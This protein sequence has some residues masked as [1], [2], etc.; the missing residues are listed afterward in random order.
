MPM[1]TSVSGPECVVAE[2]NIVSNVSNPSPEESSRM[3]A[4]RDRQREPTVK[5]I[6]AA[7][8]SQPAPARGAWL[9]VTIS[10]V[11]LWASFTPLD[12]SPLA[13]I[14]LAPLSLLV[15]LERAPR[16][17]WLVTYVGGLLFWLP[18]LQWMRLG[19]A[20]MYAA[21]FALVVYQAAYWPAFVGLSRVAVHRFNLPLTF[22][23][24]LV[25]TGLEFVRAHLMTG[26]AW[27]FLGHSQYRWTELIQLS[28]VFGAYG[29]SFVV[30]LSSAMLAGLMPQSWL[31]GLR[32]LAPVQLPEELRH[33]PPPDE[34]S[35]TTA[36]TTWRRQ[37][38]S[39]A[40]CL[41]V[42]ATALGYGFVRRG[43]AEFQPG[44]RVALIQGNFLSSMKHD[45]S[46]FRK[47]IETHDVLTGYSVP[48]KPDIIIWPETMFRWPLSDFD[49]NLSESDLRRLVPGVPVAHWSD[50]T[51]RKR[52]HEMSQMSGANMLI[53]LD[54]LQ[55]ET[56]GLKHFNSV[57]FVTPDRGVSGTYD[58]LH[59][60]IFGE[61]IPLKDTFPWLK[62]FSP[63]SD[64]FG[65]TAGAGPVA[66]DCGRWRV[67]PI[68]CFEDTVPHLV[69]DIVRSAH[70][71][72]ASASAE[73][74]GERGP[75]AST[76]VERL[77][78]LLNLTND[79]WFHGSSELDQH[80]I[81]STFRAVEFRT[82]LVRAVNTGISAVIDGDGVI[83][84]PEVFIDGDATW[85]QKRELLQKAGRDASNRR[86]PVSMF[87][88]AHSTLVDPETGRWRK[89]LNA[90]LV[91]TVPLDNR[92][93]LYL[94]YGDWFAATCA[95]ACALFLIVGFLP[96]R[97]SQ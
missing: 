17:T 69:R 25:W 52:L 18:T 64:E 58:K 60:V 70:R 80:L 57:A 5:E 16:L 55:V 84:E 88:V 78:C 9:L 37:V 3:A 41:L 71:S 11:L 34:T 14:A 19:D 7:A 31:R 81:T 93:S 38:A 74:A 2:A 48:Y 23:A 45:P 42:L 66:F 86:L 63:I 72:L 83:R 97:S 90:A 28:D 47:I 46:E 87:D 73:R 76:D 54:R 21:W 8:R 29:V 35:L 82:P 62:A 79:G 39:V 4:A 10:A 61:Y 91:D 22:A 95:A 1:S 68:I 77:A 49:P 30:A 50:L 94:A 67:A 89:S 96:K 51:V 44:P 43:Q 26:F 40:A 6:I 24:P 53:G 13:W 56:S 36:K 75:G 85:D 15:R 65:I 32:L 20:S 92:R 12:W 59:R 27:Y 33:L